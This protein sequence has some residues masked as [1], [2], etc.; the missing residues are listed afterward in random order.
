M[1]SSQ[2]HITQPHMAQVK[3]DG[4]SPTPSSHVAGPI[5]SFPAQASSEGH[6]GDGGRRAIP[7]AP[8]ATANLTV[9]EWAHGESVATRP[10]SWL[11]LGGPSLE[12]GALTA[13]QR[14]LR[15][16][17]PQC[18]PPLPVTLTHT[19]PKPLQ[20][21]LAWVTLAFVSPAGAAQEGKAVL[22]QESPW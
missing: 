17:Q 18:F 1:G 7:E 2:T 22:K 16:S 9:R 5:A 15:L 8:L 4:D 14:E 10:T 20:A 21:P 12:H 6:H 13:S 3:S 19:R 11:A